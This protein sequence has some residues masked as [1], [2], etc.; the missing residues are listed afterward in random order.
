M[1]IGEDVLRV[2]SLVCEGDCRCDRVIARVTVGREAIACRPELDVVAGSGVGEGGGI[3]VVSLVRSDDVAVGGGVG[4]GSG[5]VL[6]EIAVA[7]E[8]G[9][10]SIVG[11]GE[12]GEMRLMGPVASISSS[13]DSSLDVLP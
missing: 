12:G 4:G 3:A 13:P 1:V 8:Q 7:C 2:L 10:R 5:G 11:G 9:G 6:L